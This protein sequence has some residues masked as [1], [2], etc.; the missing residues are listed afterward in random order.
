MEGIVEPGKEIF[1]D[2]LDFVKSFCYLGG[3][4]NTNCGSKAEMTART[5]IG[6]TKF[7]ECE[8]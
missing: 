4:F 1:F 5:I 6:W 8:E 7:R 2:L 3:R